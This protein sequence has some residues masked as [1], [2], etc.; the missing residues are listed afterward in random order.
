MNLSPKTRDNY[1]SYLSGYLIPYFEDKPLN[2]ITYFDVQGMI[3]TCTTEKIAKTARGVLSSVLGHAATAYHLLPFNVAE[4]R[5]CY[6]EPKS[7]EKNQQGLVLTTFEEMFRWLD[8]LEHYDKDGRVYQAAI[9]CLGMGMRPEET[10]GLDCQRIGMH[11]GSIEIMQAYVDATDGQHLKKLKTPSSRRRLPQPKHVYERL[12]VM[13]LDEGPY[14]RNRDGSRAAPDY[15]ARRFKELRIKH[16]LP[17]I[18]FASMRHSFA[19]ICLCAGIDLATLSLWMGH[20]C[21]DTTLRFYVK[22]NIDDLRKDAVFMDLLFDRYNGK[23]IDVNRLNSFGFSDYK[24]LNWS[25]INSS[26]DKLNLKQVDPYRIHYHEKDKKRSRRGLAS[27]RTQNSVLEQFAKN[28]S[29]T[30]VEISKRL[31]ISM[32]TVKRCVVDLKSRKLL[33]R[34]GSESSVKWI[35]ERG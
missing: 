7:Y 15:I 5:Y 30:Q 25:I 1:R 20:S 32:T 29:I 24:G 12:S 19:T 9:T 14:I 28:P 33:T 6:P 4:A 2:E 31:N 3:N 13:N 18:T 27:V 11:D 21:S 10:Y 16:D 8:M 17:R 22:P 35:V 23:A 34:A 26:L